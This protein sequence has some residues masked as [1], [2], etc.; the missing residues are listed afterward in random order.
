[1]PFSTQPELEDQKVALFPLQ[2]TD[3][4]S[5]Y[6]VAS[7]PAIWAQHPNKDRWKR[8]VFRVFFE[9]AM[10]SGGAFRIVDKLTGSIAGSTRMYDYAPNEDS[11]LIGYTFFAT[12]FWGKGYNPAVKTLMLDYLFQHVSKVGFHIGAENIRSQIAI[13]RLGAVKTGEQEIAYFGEPSK[14]NFI[15]QIQKADWPMPPAAA[16]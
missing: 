10:Q 5:L 15:Y 8:D 9:G 16:K 2:E 14:L 4:E 3:F 12:R 6:A 7:D 11:I 1:M 13:T